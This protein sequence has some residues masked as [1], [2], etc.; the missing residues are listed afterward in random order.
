M[1]GPA[2]VHPETHV[3]DPAV[4]DPRPRLA[5]FAGPNATVLVTE[6]LVTSDKARAARGLP[7]RAGPGGRQLRFDAL[8]PQR[9][10]APATVWVEAYSAHPLEADAAHL[11][12]PPDGWMDAAGTVHAAPTGPTDRPV[13]RVDLRPEDGPYPLPYMAFQADGRP[14]E[15]DEADPFGPPGRH[16][17]PFFPD[18]ARLFEEIDRLGVGHDGVASVLDRLA[19]YDFLRPAPPAGPTAAGEVAGRDFF[20]YRPPHLLRQPDRTVLARLTNAVQE[21]LGSGRYDGGL[22]LEGSP[23]VEET[24]WWL[25]LLIDAPVPLV[26]CASE[27]PHGSLGNDGDANVVDA[28]RWLV[29]R[30]WADPD[31]RDA[32]G[33]VVVMDQQVL[34]ARA[35][36]KADARPGGF[37]TAGPHG[38]I[39]GSVSSTGRVVLSFRPLAR[40]TWRSAVRL[41]ELPAV[42]PGV[43]PGGHA[44]EVPV[45]DDAGALL[46]SAVPTVRILAHGQYVDAPG[47]PSA[48]GEVAVTA[49]LRAWGAA[50]PLAGFVAEGSAPFGTTSENLEAALRR[51]TFSGRPVVKVGRGNARGVTEGTYAPYAVAGGT[52]TATKA[53]L[54]L[55]ACLLRFG[56]PPPAADP[57][58]PTPAETRATQAVLDRYRAVFADH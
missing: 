24:A 6:P 36:Q 17:Q 27:R 56:A 25:N 32:I 43:G 15:G 44:V 45:R 20:P 37:E 40:H 38:G 58:A 31:G 55:M 4:P 49:L 26:A 13:L 16:R 57:D 29:S 54:L 18:A 11:Y 3:T 7:P 1:P 8:R 51:A 35:A 12:A 30:A 50:E 19:A 5:V 41:T 22:W 48:D 34:A 39:L 21:A 2:A 23:H 53:R 14:W 52:L 42:V 9:L 46:G 47:G 28:V 10:A 33:A